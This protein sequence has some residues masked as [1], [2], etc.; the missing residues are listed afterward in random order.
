MTM[1]AYIVDDDLMVRR[2]VSRLLAS[3][4][5]DHDTFDSATAFLAELDSLDFGCVLLDINMPETNGL[6][7]LSEILIRRPH[8][9]VIMVSGSTNVDDAIEAFRRGAIHF[10]RKP[11]RRQELLN[12]L[13]E[14]SV[15]GAARLDAYNRQRLASTIRLSTR[16]HQV[17]EA[18]A[19]GKQS[20]QI[21]WSLNLSIRTV[22]MHRSNLLAKM[23]AGTASQA[24][25]IARSLS[26]LSNPKVAA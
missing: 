15:I 22:E 13:E 19:D 9:P 6:D 2:V 26:L 21:A 14:A 7:I 8:F 16:E 24:V 25:A 20:K 17:L 5:I 3:A 18:I 11:Y 10:L 23:S 4:G 12:A 1:R